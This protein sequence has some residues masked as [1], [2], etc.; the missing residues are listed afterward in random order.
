VQA[1]I[2]RIRLA[3]C[4]V[5]GTTAPLFHLLKKYS[6]TV[7]LSGL[8]WCELM[9]NDRV[10]GIAGAEAEECLLCPTCTVE[11]PPCWSSVVLRLVDVMA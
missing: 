9:V 5:P 10:S 4:A 1:T 3:D 8:G 2:P 7:L 6:T 11:V